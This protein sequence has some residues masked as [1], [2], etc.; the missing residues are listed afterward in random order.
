MYLSWGLSIARL[1]AAR[2]IARLDAVTAMDRR[3]DSHEPMSKPKRTMWPCSASTGPALL[4][5]GEPASLGALKGDAMEPASEPAV[6]EL[7][8]PHPSESGEREPL[9]E[10]AAGATEGC[11]HRRLFRSPSIS[12]EPGGEVRSAPMR[13][14]SLP[15]Q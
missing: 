13:T 3:V 11:S 15:S 14:M 8:A 9:H 2:A 5:R 1:R 10:V 12:D 6:P 4:V 7:G